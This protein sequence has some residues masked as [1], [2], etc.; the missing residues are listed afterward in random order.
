MKGGLLGW[1]VGCQLGAIGL[2]NGQAGNPI[3]QPPHLGLT[4]TVMQGNLGTLK[5]GG[6]VRMTNEIGNLIEKVTASLQQSHFSGPSRFPDREV[7]L[8]PKVRLHVND[9]DLEP[10]LRSFLSAL[11]I[12]TEKKQYGKHTAQAWKDSY[13]FPLN[14]DINK[15]SELYGQR[16]MN[17][18][19][20]RSHT[21][22]K[23]ED[24]VD[25]WLQS[26]LDL[27]VDS[28]KHGD[29]NITFLCGGVG[30]GKSTFIRY[31]IATRAPRFVSRK[32]IPSRIEAIKVLRDAPAQ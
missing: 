23:S 1:G 28:A 27:V 10:S 13:V 15:A 5:P 19:E 18:S 31:L 11:E 9:R 3:R 29:S 16:G 17:N 26:Y 20:F 32:V 25:S 21:I 24:D 6:F 30:S 7:L 8:P 2:R 14:Q 12:A 4:F 22:N